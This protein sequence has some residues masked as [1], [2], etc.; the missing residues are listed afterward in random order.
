MPASVKEDAVT[1]HSGDVS[2]AVASKGLLGES[3]P[4]AAILAKPRKGD[5]T[6]V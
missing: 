2:Q 1:T 5:Q 3:G 4:L 6:S